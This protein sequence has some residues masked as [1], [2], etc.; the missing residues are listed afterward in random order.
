MLLLSYFQ[1]GGSLSNNTKLYNKL[2]I[3]ENKD[4]IKISVFR[5]TILLVNDFLFRLTKFL[6]EVLQFAV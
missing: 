3:S 1:F 4:E 5:K 2:S 6:R